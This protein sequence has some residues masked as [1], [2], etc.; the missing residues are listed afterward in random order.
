[1]TETP[2]KRVA[3]AIR[4]RR[5]AMALTQV[6]M[7]QLSGVSEP[8]W[9]DLETARRE[10]FDRRTLVKVCRALGWSPESIDRIRRGEDP[11]VLTTA[12]GAFR[13]AGTSAT[14]GVGD[15]QVAFSATAPVT[16]ATARQL[17][18]L[19]QRLLDE[20]GIRPNPTDP[21]PGTRPPRKAEP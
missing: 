12:E 4:A 5:D 2:A 20:G 7:S 21:P 3:V 13:A 8:V 10:N 16:E 6:E 14:A 18:D 1:M 15:L 11:V 17:V 19:L 9:G